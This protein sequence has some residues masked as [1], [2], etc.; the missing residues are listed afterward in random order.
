MHA[1]V[2]RFVPPLLGAALVAACGS[3]EGPSQVTIPD[4][5]FIYALAPLA[6]TYEGVDSTAG[7]HFGFSWLSA[8]S[9]FGSNCL[10]FLPRTPTDSIG[11]FVF[12][13][14]GQNIGRVERRSGST[15]LDTVTGFFLAPQAPGTHGTYIVDSNGKLTLNWANGA[16]NRYFAV[17][18]VLRLVSDTVESVA[19]LRT[20]GDSIRDQWHVVWTASPSC[21]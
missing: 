10:A 17:D 3:V 9:F 1:V 15:V 13:V 19:D 14:V 7:N 16:R 4:G 8:E 12:A 20:R 18:A 2:R 11:T 5:S 6:L 21:P